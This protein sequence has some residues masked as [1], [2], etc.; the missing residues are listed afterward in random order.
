LW[1]SKLQITVRGPTFFSA[2]DESAMFEWLH[3]IKILTVEGIGADLCFKLRRRPTD[4]QLRDLLALFFRYGLNM[5]PLAAL[6]TPANESWFADPAK[7]WFAAVFAEHVH[8]ARSTEDLEAEAARLE[9]FV[10]RKVVKTVW[11]RRPAELGIE[12][13]DGARLFVD[14]HDEGLEFSIGRAPTGE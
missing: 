7:Y 5:R 11:R 10:G 1:W 8:V 4:G 12:F 2:N 9:S 14:G 3:K 6:R 13:H